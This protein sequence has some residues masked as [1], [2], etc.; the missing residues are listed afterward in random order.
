AMRHDPAQR[1]QTALE[2]FQEIRA[3]LPNGWGI[4]DDMLVPLSETARE[5]QAPRAQISMPP[6]PPMTTIARAQGGENVITAASQPGLSTAAVAGVRPADP[7]VTNVALATQT[8]ATQTGAP[9]A[10][11]R[12]GLVAGVAVG[13]LAVIGGAA[14]FVL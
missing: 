11:S 13:T 6:P 10:G 12:K 4:T 3:I 2:M 1:Y 7:G 8:G 9:Q 14:Y 5:R